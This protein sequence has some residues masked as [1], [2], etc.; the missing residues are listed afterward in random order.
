MQLL[1]RRM[2][3]HAVHPQDYYG[4]NA[5]VCKHV[6][7]LVEAAV[8]RDDYDAALVAIAVWLRFSAARHLTWNRNYNVKPREIGAAQVRVLSV[9]VC[10][11]S[12]LA[13][14]LWVCIVDLSK[15]R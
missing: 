9:F 6:Q 7:G 3:D 13:S 15:G 1:V 10:C 14:R 2:G 8:M 12:A 4:A 5:E 11:W